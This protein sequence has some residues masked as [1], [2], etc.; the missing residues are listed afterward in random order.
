MWRVSVLPTTFG[1]SMTAT[2]SRTTIL[3]GAVEQ[4]VWK[5]IL[6]GSFFSPGM[7]AGQRCTYEVD[8]Q[9]LVPPVPLES[10]DF[11]LVHHAV[12]KS[13]LL[14]PRRR[15]EIA[16]RRF[17]QVEKQLDRGH[18]QLPTQRTKSTKRLN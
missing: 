13:C 3:F 4:S 18:D 6:Y 5:A 14:L 1:M 9:A 17:F 2:F 8:L 15:P 10:V 16:V 11:S 7:A 12:D